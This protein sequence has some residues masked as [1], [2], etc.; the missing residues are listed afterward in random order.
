MAEKIFAELVENIV[1]LEANCIIFRKATMN[2][3]IMTI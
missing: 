2:V 3:A 1:T